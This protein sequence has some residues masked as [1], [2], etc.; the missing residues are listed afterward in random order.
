MLLERGASV[1]SKHRYG[2]TALTVAIVENHTECARILLCH[3]ADPNY[4]SDANYPPLHHAVARDNAEL[5]QVLLEHGADDKAVG[6]N[7]QTAYALAKHNE[8]FKIARLFRGKK[9][10]C[11]CLSKQTKVSS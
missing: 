11:V 7:G 10:R 1:D 4:L 9:C 3:G 2:G 8:V 6:P 5:V